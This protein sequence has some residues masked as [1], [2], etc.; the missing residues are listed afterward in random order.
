[1]KIGDLVTFCPESWGTPL[2]DRPIGIV[3]NVENTGHAELLVCV[4]FSH[5]DIPYSSKIQDFEVVN[6]NW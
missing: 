3:M 2:E 6:E 5:D 1:V 4:K